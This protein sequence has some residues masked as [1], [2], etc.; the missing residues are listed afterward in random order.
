[1]LRQL[2]NFLGVP[3]PDAYR[4][5]RPLILI[6]GLAE[7]GESWYLNRNEWQ[8]HFDVHTPGVLVYDGPV[9][10]Q[11][12]ADD[13]PVTIDFLTNRLAEYLDRFVQLPPY[14]IVA[15]SLGGQ[16]AVEYAARCPDKV[17]RIV[18]ICPSGIGTEERLPIMEAA[19]H[20]NFQ[21]LVESTFYDHRHASPRVV[22]YYRRRFA[23][24]AWRR[25]FFETVRGTKNHSVRDKLAAIT[26]PVLVVCGREDRIV[27]P[28]A[29]QDAVRDLPN[30]RCEMIDRCGHAPQ[31]ER[32]RLV[33]RMVMDF[34]CQP[35]PD[36][37]ERS[38]P[39]DEQPVLAG[40]PTNDA[41]RRR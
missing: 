5:A 8:R 16:I 26:R 35:S 30:Y 24:R 20:K 21:G 34:L 3:R 23:S 37:P 2:L 27:E 32:S 11:R 13:L 18:L 4:R 17:D 40:E 6:N 7:Q 28:L 31:L 41:W 29:V 14:H 15:S 33:N 9:M 12:L 10:Q 25:A 19:R 22:E 38:A 36:L 39:V 1:M